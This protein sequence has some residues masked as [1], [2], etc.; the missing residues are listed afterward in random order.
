MKFLPGRPGLAKTRQQPLFQIRDVRLAASSDARW[1]ELFEKADVVSEGGAFG[2]GPER[3]YFGSSNIVLLLRP[4]RPGV[5]ME[6]LASAVALDPHVRVR[7]LRMARREAE[8][9]ANG[10]LDRVRAEITVSPSPRGVAVHVDVHAQV[11][12]DRRRG[13]RSA[14]SDSDRRRDPRSAQS[15]SDRRRDPRSAP[16]DSDRRRDRRSAPSNPDRRALPRVPGAAAPAL[17]SGLVTDGDL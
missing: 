5:T 11:F 6:Q 4:E 2:E 9:R 14:P 3:A 13:P 17:E 16:S 12:P 10:P 1:S 7:A 15:D 8:Q